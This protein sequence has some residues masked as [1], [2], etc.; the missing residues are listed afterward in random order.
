MRGRGEER[1]T[2]PGRL[3]I[4]GGSGYLGRA[5]AA[6][7]QPDWDVTATRL[8]Q[9]GQGPVLDVRDAAA[10]GRLI[11]RLRPD[12]IVH[13]AYHQSGE[14]MA[15]VNVAGANNVA[16]AAGAV[17]ARLVHLST[18]L[19]FDGGRERGG[20]SEDDAAS[21]I[22]AYGRSKLAGERA[23]LAAEPDALIVRTSLIYGGD[24]PG[25]HEGMVLEALDGRRDVAFFSDE[26]RCPIVADDLAEALLDLARQPVSGCCT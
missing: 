12:V 22:T 20:Y 19:V 1:R 4:T 5:L 21:P 10:V 26:M 23:V 13:T 8:T 15:D 7:A 9:P 16:R 25:A 3:L 11:E 18:D 14:Q 17:G 6:R 24:P 2:Q